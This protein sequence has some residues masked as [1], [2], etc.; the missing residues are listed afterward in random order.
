MPRVKEVS[1]VSTLRKYRPLFQ[2]K[3]K[4]SKISLERC[5]LAGFLGL[6]GVGLVQ[7]TLVSMAFN[8]SAPATIQTAGGA[9]PVLA[10]RPSADYTPVGSIE[11]QQPET[12]AP[13]AKT[14][15]QI[16]LRPGR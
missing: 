1:P 6:T 15:G 8:D 9:S 12:P 3:K 13:A 14:T 4:K 5:L 16:G 2:E 11:R 10:A 7:P